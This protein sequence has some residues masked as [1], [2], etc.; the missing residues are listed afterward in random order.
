MIAFPD[1]DKN[2]NLYSDL[3]CE[4]KKNGHEVYVSTILER[5]F[6][7]KTSFREESSLHVLRVAT[8]DLFNVGFIRK[9]LTTLS[10]SQRFK[11]AIKKY[12]PNVKFDLIIFPTPPI[13]FLNVVKFIKQRDGSQSYLVLRDIFPQNAKDLGLMRFGWL[14]RYFRRLER[15]LYDIADYIGCMSNKNMEYI[16]EHNDIDED[17]CELLP[18]WKKIR[19]IDG[20]GSISYRKKY[21]L[22]NKF[23]AIFAGVIGIAQELGFLLELA[24]SYKDR[25][26]IVFFIIGDGNEKQKLKDIVHRE[27]LSN[28][29]IRDRI[30]S[31][32]LL[33]LVRECDVGLVN[34]NRKFTIPNFPSKALD[35]FEAGLPV[36][37]SIDRNTDY[38][39]L[40]EESKGGLWSVTGDLESYRN[41]FEKLL[42]NEE[43]RLALGKN[44]RKYLESN[45][46]V[47]K[48]YRTIMNH[49][50]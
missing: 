9:G 17:K 42:S 12:F 15:K 36:L 4:F 23:V 8:G 49:F 32:E 10:L 6:Q 13:T 31:R 39:Q 30:P 48:T 14:F 26:D 40:L 20:N 3:A 41:N 2:P 28:V 37:A 18:N 7:Q 34:L 38:G 44:G 50:R 47:E 16:L 27:K 1:I 25:E 24:K 29:I 22:E 33:L 46:T 35:Y 11:R 21:G 19:N 43:Y 45:L 5:K